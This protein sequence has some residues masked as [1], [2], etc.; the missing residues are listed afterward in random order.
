MHA[1]RNGDNTGRPADAPPP[2]SMRGM[3]RP[4]SPAAD[5][6]QAEYDGD[7][8]ELERRMEG[9][10]SR[11]LPTPLL[12]LGSTSS[13]RG[14]AAAGEQ[15]RPTSSGSGSRLQVGFVQ[16]LYS[17][18]NDETLAPY[19]SWRHGGTVFSVTNPTT[20]AQHVLPNWFKH[21]NF[22]SFVS[23][24][25]RLGPSSPVVDPPPAASSPWEFH[26][27]SFHRDHPE[28]LCT[29]IRKPA[30]GSHRPTPKSPASRTP[31]SRGSSP[32]S[33]D[34]PGPA[35]VHHFHDHRSPIPIKV[36]P[37]QQFPR[38]TTSPSLSLEGPTPPGTAN[39]AMHLHEGETGLGMM[40]D[41]DEDVAGRIAGLTESVRGLSEA[42]ARSRQDAAEERAA[43]NQI[44]WMLLDIVSQADVTGEQR[45]EREFPSSFDMVY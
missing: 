18:L 28:L 27:P 36:E 23:V 44:M 37:P 35:P 42:L 43:A 15:M 26:H 40:Q 29:I 11:H 8:E 39:A 25:D 21:A 9:G 24:N 45:H 34:G 41:D 6:M 14:A 22:Q 4:S 5:D 31:S 19:L 2:A 10:A 3:V 7:E 17:M 33:D 20:F 32:H 16:K 1:R 13:S 30:K 12:P 38:L